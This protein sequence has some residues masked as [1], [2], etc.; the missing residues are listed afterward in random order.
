M[1]ELMCAL[2]FGLYEMS[3]LILS[4]TKNKVPIHAGY[5]F[6]NTLDS[7]VVLPGAG[8]G[9]TKYGY[10]VQPFDDGSKGFL[11]PVWLAF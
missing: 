9:S 5:S 8:G 6:G 10:W 2:Y 3:V 4:L 11:Q 1:L 7:Y